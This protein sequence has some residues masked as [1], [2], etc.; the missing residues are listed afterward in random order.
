MPA[1]AGLK[2][3]LLRM[4]PGFMK[5]ITAGLGSTCDATS[6]ESAMMSPSGDSPLLPA[7]TLSPV[8]LKSVVM[9]PTTLLTSGAEA[10]S[11]WPTSA[12]MPAS[13]LKVGYAV[14]AGLVPVSLT[15]SLLSAAMPVILPVAVSS[16]RSSAV[17]YSPYFPALV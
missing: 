12:A 6:C 7:D 2:Y 11:Y 17:R 9:V 16:V 3:R 4:P 5:A 14:G 15:T 13:G 8:V 10:L 1:L